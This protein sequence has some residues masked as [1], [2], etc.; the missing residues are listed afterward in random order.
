MKVEVPHER[1]RFLAS[2]LH[3]SDLAAVELYRSLDDEG[4][5]EVAGMLAEVR[6][7]VGKLKE[8][9][10]ARLAKAEETAEG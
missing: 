1:S 2:A 7:R 4:R 3:S 10:A 8:K 5:E 6:S 9:N